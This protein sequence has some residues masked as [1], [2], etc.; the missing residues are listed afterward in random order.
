MHSYDELH[1]QRLRG[2]IAYESESFRRELRHEDR[3]VDRDAWREPSASARGAKQKSAGRATSAS[4]RH[5]SWSG[6]SRGGSRRQPL[7]DRA[8]GWRQYTCA[9]SARAALDEH[10]NCQCTALFQACRRV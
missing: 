3:S 1:N 6:S 8:R 7:A 2:Q 5:S 10:V 9:R 4:G